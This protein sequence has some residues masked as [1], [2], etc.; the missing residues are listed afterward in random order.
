MQNYERGSGAKLNT[1][2]SELMWLGGWR[3]RDDVP[4]GFKLVTKMKILGVYFSNG[5]ISVDNDNWRERLD[6]LEKVLKLWSQRDLSFLGRAMIVNALGAS[7]FW[8][9][10]KILIP[11]NW[12]HERFNSIIWPFIWKGK[13]E[14]VSRQRCCAPLV[15]GGLN[16]VDFKS[17]C[18]CLR[19]SNFTSFRDHFGSEKWHFIARYF[20][21][22][23]LFLL[24][25]RFSFPSNLMPSSLEP[26]RF[27]KSCLS[28]FQDLY[29]KFGSL[30]DDLSCKNL[31]SLLHE[32][33]R[34]APRCA[35]FWESGLS[36]PTN[37]WASVWRKSRFKLIKNRKNDLMWLIIHRVVRT[38]YNLKNWGYIRTDKCSMC[39]CVE[40][41]EHC[42]LE[43]PRARVVWKLFSPI[44][45]RFFSIP[46]PI[47]PLSI[48]YPFSDVSLHALVR[49]L[50]A[51]ILYWIWNARNLSTFRNSK[52]SSK[53]IADLI[54]R[55]IHFR[56]RCEPI[57]AVKNLW[58]FG[59]ILCSID[60]ENHISFHL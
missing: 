53:K 9:T 48:F 37:W 13:M 5:L 25:D 41:I 7:R 15:R 3:A 32:L 46:F 36:R 30:P 1:S 56:I 58:S 55:D 18:V 26:S 42:F 12:V 23:R 20:L 31:Y 52:I 2:K 16:I 8:H 47:S 29:A 17:K 6:K 44:L 4:F 51:T 38:R 22:K 24:D 54:T 40:T 49:Y 10:A 11:P 33:P 45:S 14:N 60:N 21:N 28:H 19:L 34:V 50:L 57:D 39:S 43:C 35:G 27:Y 59:D